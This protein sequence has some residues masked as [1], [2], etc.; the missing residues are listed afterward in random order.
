MEEKVFKMEELEQFVH[1]HIQ[2]KVDS[3]ELGLTGVNLNDFNEFKR[4]MFIYENALLEGI[5]NGIV[6]CNGKV[7]GIEVN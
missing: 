3:A 2:Q 7:E 5:I 4:D 1:D 6:M